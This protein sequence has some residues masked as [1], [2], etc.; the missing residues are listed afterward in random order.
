[1]K[2]AV[3]VRVL[4]FLLSAVCLFYLLSCCAL[5]FGLG[6]GAK[7]VAADAPAVASSWP[8]ATEVAAVRVELGRGTWNLLHRMAAKY[9]AA[10]SAGARSAMAAFF[11]TL[12]DVYPCDEC[13]EHF[14]GLLA[15]PG[16][17][18][19]LA[20]ATASGEALGL[21][22]C[23]RHNDVN[24][25]L[26]KPAFPCTPEALAERWGGCGCAEGP[27]AQPAPPPP[28]QLPLPQTPARAAAD[29][30]AGAPPR[31]RA[32]RAHVRRAVK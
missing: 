22:L 16:A 29:A 14:R 11:V 26:G 31:T 9:P 30:D 18:A 32:G 10:P 6:G 28:A 19:A 15:A 20:D 25:R 2:S 5:F 17:G 4:G 7:A 24:A 3:N 21:W 1:M 23:A 8:A 12:G 13:A 27:G